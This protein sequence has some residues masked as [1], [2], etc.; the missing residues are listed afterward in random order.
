MTSVAWQSMAACR[1]M[2]VNVFFPERGE[3][4]LTARQVCAGCGVREE[5][6]EF[7]LTHM[8]RF[9]VWGGMSERERGRARVDRK[10]RKE[11]YAVEDR[12]RAAFGE[13]SRA[14]YQRQVR[15]AQG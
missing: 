9:G 5:C 15:A 6:R 7:A 2:D 10:I 14:E 3:L 4:L 11:T 13:H 1:G 12:G 8:E